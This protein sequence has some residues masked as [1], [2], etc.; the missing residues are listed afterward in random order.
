MKAIIFDLDD[1]IGERSCAWFKRHSVLVD[2]LAGVPTTPSQEI[3]VGSDAI[4]AIRNA[5]IS[6]EE[7][8]EFNQAVFDETFRKSFC[9]KERIGWRKE[10]LI[11][12]HN[13]G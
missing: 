7:N 11:S 5:P 13:F 8:R 9:R 10:K 12:S 1:H 3:E 2:R 4:S 6:R